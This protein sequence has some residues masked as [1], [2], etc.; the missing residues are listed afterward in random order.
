MTSIQPIHGG[1]DLDEISTRVTGRIYQLDPELGMREL[2]VR[3]ELTYR[4]SQPFELELCFRTPYDT[5]SVTWCISRE[6]LA[7]GLTTAS[8]EADD[9]TQHLA[10]DV[11]IST[12]A[13]PGYDW[14]VLTLR[15]PSGTADIGMPTHELIQFV[16]RTEDLVAVGT[17]GALITE[18]DLAALLADGS[19]Q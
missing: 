16:D 13:L 5:A 17:E 12:Y 6:L 8:P 15:S 7:A 19:G 10:A 14:T 18:A 1:F 4:R 9:T 11:Q 2:P 3:V